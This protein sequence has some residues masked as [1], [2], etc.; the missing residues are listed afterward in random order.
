MHVALQ[1]P[2]DK[3]PG[4]LFAVE[5]LEE[6]A[7]RTDEC[8]SEDL[9][10]AEA[11]EHET[12]ALLDL[13]HFCEQLGVVVH[14]HA[15]LAKRL[16][17]RVVLFLCFLRPEHV[18]EQQLADVLGREAGQLQPWPVEDGLAELAD[19]GVNMK[20]HLGSPVGFLLSIIRAAR[21]GSDSS[22]AA[23]SGGRSTGSAVLPRRCRRAFKKA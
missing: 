10:R 16:C 7:E 9:R 13:Q 22:T 6:P 15:L 20:R 19:L 2:S 17:E 23:C 8:R 11:V 1:D 5:I 3:A 18:V 14:T 21:A 12:P 4:E